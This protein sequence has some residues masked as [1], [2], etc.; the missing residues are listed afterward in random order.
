MRQVGKSNNAV[1]IVADKNKDA[2]GNVESRP[3]GAGDSRERVG[4]SS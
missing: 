2:V 4:G 1:I 3:P